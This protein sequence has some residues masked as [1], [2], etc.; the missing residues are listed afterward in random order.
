MK[1]VRFTL[2]VAAAGV[3]LFTSAAAI[4]QGLNGPD[5]N[6]SDAPVGS[7]ATNQGALL[8][9]AAVNSTGTIAG[10]GSFVASSALLG[11]GNYE[12]IFKGACRNITAARGWARWVQVDTLTD[13]SIDNVTCTTANRAGNQDGVW[14]R[15]TD[16]A[17]TGVN[18]SF[19]LFV[20]R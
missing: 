8:C 4:G 16:G 13:G 7:L 11:T 3:A 19:F 2:A 9:V 17:G 1:N 6:A 15:C 18:T 14:V 10:G 12:V 5:V 20:A